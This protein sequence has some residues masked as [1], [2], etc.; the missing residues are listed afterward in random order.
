MDHDGHHHDVAE[1]SGQVEPARPRE[2]GGKHQAG[3]QGTAAVKGGHWADQDRHAGHSVATFRDKFWLSLALTVP[4]VV[5]S[6]DIQEW[7]GYSVPTIPGIEYAPAIPG[8]IV[9]LMTLISLAIAVAFVSSWAGRG[10]LPPDLSSSGS[11]PDAPFLLPRNNRFRD[12][13][14]GV[15]ARRTRIIDRWLLRTRAYSRTRGMLPHARHVQARVVLGARLSP[16]A[17]WP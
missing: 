6:H 16:T 9:L 14:A 4:I 12:P 8:S 3:H 15:G 1:R 17:S 7:F 13:R 5:L 10:E 2:G 11:R